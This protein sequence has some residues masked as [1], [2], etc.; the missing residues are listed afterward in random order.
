MPITQSS[1]TPEDFD[2][3]A[4]F[5]TACSGEKYGLIPGTAKPKVRIIISTPAEKVWMPFNADELTVLITD[6][7]V[8]SRINKKAQT[9]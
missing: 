9:T 3:S 5:L 6:K 8:D 2:S 1:L 4:A 7:A